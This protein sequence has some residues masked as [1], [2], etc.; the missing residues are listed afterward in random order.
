MG[1]TAPS[2]KDMDWEVSKKRKHT[3]MTRDSMKGVKVVMWK[4]DGSHLSQTSSG[5][6]PGGR[7][8]CVTFWQRL[9]R[10]Q[11]TIKSG[12]VHSR[13]SCDSPSEVLQDKDNDE[14]PSW[15]AVPIK[16]P[17]A[18]RSRRWPQGW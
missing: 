10:F 5:P 2:L 11:D 12:P 18:F 16:L 13:V 1:L 3:R 14:K 17:S 6:K 9:M 8:C 4:M 15:P 7:V